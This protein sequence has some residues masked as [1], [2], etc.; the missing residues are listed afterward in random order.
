MRDYY[1]KNFKGQYGIE[2]D[3]SFLKDPLIVNDIFMKKPQRIEALVV[4]LLIFFT[5]LEAEFKFR[6]QNFS[7]PDSS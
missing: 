3:Y 4:V 1:N 5:Y 7:P 2:R 6:T